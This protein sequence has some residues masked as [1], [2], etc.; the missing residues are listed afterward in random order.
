MLLSEATASSMKVLCQRYRDALPNMTDHEL[1]N[2]LRILNKSQT[3][4]E[5]SSFSTIDKNGVGF[6]A[7]DAETLTTA[8]KEYWANDESFDFETR[9]RVRYRL[10]KYA[11]QL[12]RFWLS[13]GA[14]TKVKNGKY[15]YESKAERLARK[16]AEKEEEIA[17][18]AVE[19]RQNNPEFALQLTP[20]YKAQQRVIQNQGQLD[21]FN[22]LGV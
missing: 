12:I 10:R 9:N 13:N 18:N 1:Y 3:E 5:K 8:M 2:C 20:E 16:A 15:E 11:E 22:E 17:R 14:I 7:F 19:Y 6:T 21:F 4:R